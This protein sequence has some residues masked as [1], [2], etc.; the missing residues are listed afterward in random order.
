MEKDSFIFYRSFKEAIDLCPDTAVKLSVYEAI[1]QYALTE[2]EP[3]LTESYAQLC[4][5]L[6]KPQLDANWRRYKN[7]KG[8]GAPRGNRNAAK[9]NRETT[10]VQ[11][12]NNRSTNDKQANVNDN[13]NENINNKDIGAKAPARRPSR[14]IPP[15]LSE[16][17]AYCRERGND[18]DPQEFVDYYTANG[19][20]QGKGKPVKDWQACVRTWERNG[21][22][23]RASSPTQTISFAGG[24]QQPPQ[25]RHKTRHS[26]L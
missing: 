11:P 21:I 6:I 24:E 22:S 12:K 14:F 5:K 1:A 18:I 25:L 2:Q 8:G 7:G 10:E 16:V 13:D 19:W 15:S 17:E 4:W 26:T 3:E 23:T 9:N 20:V